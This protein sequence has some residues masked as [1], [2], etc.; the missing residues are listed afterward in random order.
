MNVQ[1]QHEVE[2]GAQVIG[3]RRPNQVTVS[4]QDNRSA[5][6]A[7]AQAIDVVSDGS[8]SDVLAKFAAHFRSHPLI[9]AQPEAPELA[10]ALDDF[11]VG[12]A[13]SREALEEKLGELTDIDRRLAE[14]LG[15]HALALELAEAAQKLAMFADAAL[16]AVDA[17][18]Q[19]WRAY[20]CERWPSLFLWAQGGALRWYHFGEGEYAGTE[21]A[22]QEVILESGPD[23]RLP[24]P[25]AP[26]RS[27]D[28]PGAMVIAPS[29]ERIASGEGPWTSVDGAA[30]TEDYE[31]AEAW[32][33]V[34]GSGE[35]RVSVD[36]GPMRELA[37]D[38]AGLYPLARHESHG[39]HS[40]EVEISPG[41]GVWSI[42]FAPGPAPPA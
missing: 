7:L 18:F 1:P 16:L 39:R 42:S 36:G 6:V 33:T 26:L 20:G 30:R 10:A 8:G 9:G 37:I 29:P 14:D 11:L 5:P 38:G 19:V 23:A 4:D 24:E 13:G 28:A 2:R 3:E 27:T 34:E 35:L 17:R 31:A 21:E 12:V 22:I 40:L 32:A 25:M 41:V 15:N